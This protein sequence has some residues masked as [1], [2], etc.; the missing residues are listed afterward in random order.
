MLCHIARLLCTC[1]YYYDYF[2]SYPMSLTSTVT[3]IFSSSVYVFVCLTSLSPSHQLK[4]N[5]ESLLPVGDHV[6]T[7]VATGHTK[8]ILAW[9]ITA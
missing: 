3:R 1:A 9:L 4:H 2:L 7:L 6:L 5:G 8:A